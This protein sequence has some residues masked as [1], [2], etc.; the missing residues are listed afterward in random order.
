MNPDDLRLNE[1]DP[2]VSEAMVFIDHFIHDNKIRMHL[3]REGL[4]LL[5]RGFD[6]E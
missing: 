3:K 5:F 4:G 6:T 2:N 1:A